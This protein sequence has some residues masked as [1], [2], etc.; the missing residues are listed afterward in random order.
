MLGNNP[1]AMPQ[2]NQNNFYADPMNNQETLA[3]YREKNDTTMQN[4][5]AS[6]WNLEIQM[7]QIT[8]ALNSRPQRALP[9]D[10]KDPRQTRN[11]KYGSDDSDDCQVHDKLESI[12]RMN[13]AQLCQEMNDT[14]SDK[15]DEH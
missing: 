7:G 4:L 9:S 3:K 14:S 8:S 6:V 13:L 1:N 10:T 12:L 15:I 11:E 2:H 5:A